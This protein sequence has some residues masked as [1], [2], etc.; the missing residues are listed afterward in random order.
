VLATEGQY[1]LP[2]YTECTIDYL[3]GIL[4]GRKKVF[5]LILGSII[6][7]YLIQR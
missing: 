1:Y 4:S 2:P 6:R 5:F 7:C 3:Q